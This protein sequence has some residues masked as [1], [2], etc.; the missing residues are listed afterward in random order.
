[1]STLHLL[2]GAI[3]ELFAQAMHTRQLSLADRY[4][5]QA[6]ILDDQLSADE[7]ASIDRLLRSVRRRQVKISDD[8]STLRLG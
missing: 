1:M 2:P 3:S 5:L 6:A 4:G 8:V 7:R